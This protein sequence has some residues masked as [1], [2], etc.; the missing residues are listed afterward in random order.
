MFNDLPLLS[1]LVWLP[2]T[3]GLITLT[4]GDR[5]STGARRI[6]FAFSMATLLLCIPLYSGFNTATAAM[7][8]EERV[9]WIEAFNIFYHMG[10]DG[11]SMP[12]I[13]LTAFITPLVVIAGWKVIN[14]RASQYM[15]AFLIMEGLMIGVFAALDAALFYVF[16][17]AM[18]I[19][20]FIVIGIWG[21][22]NRVYATIKF[23]LYT[24][25][26]S[27]FML[28]ALLYSSFVTWCMH[29]A[30]QRPM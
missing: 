26:G 3:G 27:V 2:I 14:V 11:I 8:Y 5:E 15:A 10:V 16:W 19:P 29:G 20:M 1:L 12:L 7:Q 6:A 22:A 23:F 24:F 4:S 17:E 13:V 18:L 9:V 21:G 30:L 28:I 25:F